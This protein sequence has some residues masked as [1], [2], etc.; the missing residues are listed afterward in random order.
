MY[1]TIIAIIITTKIPYYSAIL[2]NLIYDQ[3]LSDKILGIIN[4]YYYTYDNNWQFYVQLMTY[5][6]VA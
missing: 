3:Q 2:Y 5:T 4:N 1:I 6:N